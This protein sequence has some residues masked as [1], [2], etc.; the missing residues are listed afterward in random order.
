[1]SDDILFSCLFCLAQDTK[2]L[3]QDSTFCVSY[4]GLACVLRT[5]I[6]TNSHHFFMNPKIKK[7]LENT[8]FPRVLKFL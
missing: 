3:A 2:S 6:H 4:L 1:M 7:T 5:R 8:G